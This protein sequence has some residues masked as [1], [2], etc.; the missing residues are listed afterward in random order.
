LANRLLVWGPA[1]FWAAVLFLLS[2]LPDV[3]GASWLPFGDKVGHLS[4]YAVLGVALAWGRGR[5]RRA[6]PHLLLLALGAL[7][8]VTDEVHQGYVPGRMPDPW[9]WVADVTG[10]VIGYGIAVRMLARAH[11][12]DDG[13]DIA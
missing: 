5:S 4:L 6:V 8:G 12:S 7:Y 3:P 2:S 9:D 11:T 1:A 10:L 13:E